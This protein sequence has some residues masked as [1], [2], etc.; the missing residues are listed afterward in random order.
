VIEMRK[1]E[2]DPGYN[3]TVAL[4]W[5][6]DSGYTWNSNQAREGETLWNRTCS[7]QSRCRF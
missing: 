5:F 7:N 4:C 3:G 1:S 2:L 6:P